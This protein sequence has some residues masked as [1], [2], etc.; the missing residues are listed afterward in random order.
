MTR[1]ILRYLVAGTVG[2]FLLA[3]AAPAL[4]QN[5]ALRGRVVNVDG[6]PVDMVEV[7]FDFVGDVKRQVKTI[8]DKNGEWVRP[9][10][11]AGGGTWTITAKKNNLMGTAEKITIKINET[12]KVPDIVIMTEADR[13]K[14][15]R[16]SVS[17]EEAAAAAK[18]AAETDKL[19]EE[20]N[21]AITAGKHDEAIE[22][23]KTLA[24]RLL[25]ERN[26]KCSACHAKMGDIYMLKKDEKEAEAAF[27]KAIEA[28][29]GKP[30]PYNALASLYNEQRKFEEATKMSAKATELMGAAG[31]SDP[32]ALYNQGVILW[33]QS[34]IAEAKAQWAKALELDPKMADA[35]YWFGM[36]SVNQGNVADAKKAFTTYLELAPKGQFADTAKAILASIK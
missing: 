3:S 19:L 31:A 12:I 18:K 14:G 15:V 9:G 33:N 28:D 27:L 2:V 25:T 8:T 36:A 16:P 10:L 11:P 22:K 29:P 35:H 26:D 13:A 24:E 4:A 30:G 21:A 32:A 23:L 17:S 20:V 7:V 34:K 1:Q 5:G 6:R